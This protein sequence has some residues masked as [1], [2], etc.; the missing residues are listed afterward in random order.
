MMRFAIFK[1]AVV[2]ILF[3]TA[4][5]AGVTDVRARSGSGVGVL[6]GQDTGSNDFFIGG[7]AE[8]GPIINSAFLVPS[9]H[10]GLNDGISVAANLDLRW[11]LL[12]LP[13]TGIRIY[14]AAGPT[15]LFTSET[16]V[17]LSLT[18]GFEIPMRNRRRYN[19]ELRFGFGDIPD[20]KFDTAV[21]FG[22]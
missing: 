6:A 9:A 4:L 16:E 10:I 20:L 1:A 17:G 22:I 14:G 18:A 8:F 19:V 11:Y 3:V 21:M 7:Q 13:E 15:M 5:L 2:A 12:P